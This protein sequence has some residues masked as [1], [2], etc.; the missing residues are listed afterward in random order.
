MTKE[1]FRWDSCQ[2]GIFWQVHYGLPELKIKRKNK[3]YEKRHSF[4]FQNRLCNK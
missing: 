3:L 1:H 2:T 4:T